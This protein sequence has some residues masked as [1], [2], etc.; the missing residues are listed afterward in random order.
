MDQ[1]KVISHNGQLVT[2]SRDVAQMI[3]KNHAH[4]LRDIKGY[5]EILTQ[6]NFGFSDFFIENSYKDS[7]GRNLRCYLLT[8]KE[9]R[10][11]SQQNDW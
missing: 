11:G 7:T 5:I 3:D 10:Y 1:L 9:L 2:D 4:L 6:S 8:K